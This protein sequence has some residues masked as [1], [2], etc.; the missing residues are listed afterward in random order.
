[1]RKQETKN[2]K[3]RYIA[4]LRKSTEGDERQTLSM[5]KQEDAIRETFPDLNIID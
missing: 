5:G 1:M 4:Y 2:Q 3:L